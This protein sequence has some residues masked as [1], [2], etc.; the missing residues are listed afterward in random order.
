MKSFNC[1]NPNDFYG[2]LPKNNPL[3]LSCICI[4]NSFNY[5]IEVNN[6]IKSIFTKSNVKS[7]NK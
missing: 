5:L 7:I 6:A 4:F 1:D 3:A 2:N